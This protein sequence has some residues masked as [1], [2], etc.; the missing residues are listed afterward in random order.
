M[1]TLMRWDPFREMMALRRTMDRLFED[2]S[3][4]PVLWEREGA[5]VWRLAV[6]VVE[7]EDNFIVQASVP[8]IKPED[9]DISLSDNVLTIKGEFKAQ[10]EKEGEKYHIR[11]RR[12]GRFMRSLSLPVP[13]NADKIDAVYENGVLT[14]TL[15]KAEEVKPKKIAIKAN[16]QKVIEGKVS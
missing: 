9:L 3:E 14:L 8:G 2:W 1:S 13:V 12:F 6:D 11:E 10:E 7:N 15:P 4:Q 5:D 16:G